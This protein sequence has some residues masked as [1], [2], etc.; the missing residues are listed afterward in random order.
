MSSGTSRPIQNRRIVPPGVVPAAGVGAPPG[1]NP[2]S[3]A[4][5]SS[6]ASP[7]SQAA[8]AAA[9]VPIEP[10]T[11]TTPEAAA[12]VARPAGS[13]P[14]ADVLQ[15]AAP[16]PP[17]SP[18]AAPVGSASVAVTSV[19]YAD[20]KTPTPQSA[21]A[22]G[23]L[24]LPQQFWITAAVVAALFVLIYWP[25]LLRLFRKTAPFVGV[26]E[27]YH[28]MF[29]PVV[30]VYYLYL[31]LDELLAAKVKPLLGNQFTRWRFISAGIIALAGLGFMALPSSPFVPQQYADYAALVGVAGQGLIGL[32]VMVVV[33]DWGLGSL[34]FGLLV[35]IYGIWPGQ[36][37]FV[38]DIGMVVAIF[39]A[40]LTLAGWGIM[41]IAWFPIA[42][43]L[44]ALPWPGLF[45]SRVAMPLQTIAAYVGVIVMQLC[46]VDAE[47]QGTVM[48]IYTPGS[49]VPR[50]LNVAEA[51][52]GI[53][54][55]M[56]FVT[57]AAAL[58]FLSNRPLWQ[59]LFVTAAAV[60]IA[61][62]SNVIRVAGQ[63][64]LDRYVSQEWSSGFAHGFAGV[65]FLIPGFIVIMGMFWLLDKLFI[66]EVVDDEEED[67]APSHMAKG[68]VA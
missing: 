53:K 36:N 64:L 59:K 67:A 34:L 30:G 10:T 15:S 60:P 11:P 5:L 45:Y 66:E 56:T 61:I 58:A 40:V 2:G 49:S 51:C 22:K 32:A 4:S 43:L 26:A 17:L 25:N 8:N 23:W 48:Y 13:T 3:P 62:L 20:P 35:S 21:S 19:S 6:P 50:P 63:G 44:C 68:G 27:W 9:A 38:K 54:S 42:F 16:V 7:A 65:V 28:A 31:H 55:L 52:A 39:G 14:A 1:A 18:P 47:Y 57:L 41:R 33:L 46:G 29:V 37:D 12:Q 24:G